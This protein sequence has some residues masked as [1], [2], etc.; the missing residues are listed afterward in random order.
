MAPFQ[1]T[2]EIRPEISLKS[3]LDLAFVILGMG[4]R[5]EALFFSLTHA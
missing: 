5:A 2:E 1:G 4:P 3:S